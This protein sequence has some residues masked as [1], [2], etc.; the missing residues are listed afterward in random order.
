MLV[1][2]VSGVRSRTLRASRS[3]ACTGMA[4][5]SNE[6][7]KAPALATSDFSGK[8]IFKIPSARRESTSSVCSSRSDASN[9]SRI[10][11]PQGAGK[12]FTCDDEDGELFSSQFLNEMKEGIGF[13]LLYVLITLYY[14]LLVHHQFRHMQLGRFEYQTDE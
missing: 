2:A 7:F 11:V 4:S 10:N 3:E 12:F 9:T 14:I 6:V 8:S 1:E 13:I 5:S